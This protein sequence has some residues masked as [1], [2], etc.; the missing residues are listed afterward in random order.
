[1]NLFVKM[2]ILP[3][4]TEIVLNKLNSATEKRTVMMVQMKMHAIL[5]VTP[6]GLLHVIG[7][8]VSSLIASVLKMEHK[9]LEVYARLVLQDPNAKTYLK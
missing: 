6:I 7:Q 4:V 2:L 5:T 1:M 9:F 3:V 8:F